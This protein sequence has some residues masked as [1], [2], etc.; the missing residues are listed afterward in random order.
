[1]IHIAVIGCGSIGLPI[2]VAFAA[3][4]IRVTGVD[5]DVDRLARLSAGTEPLTEP[6]LA[7]ALRAALAAGTINFTPNL[8][9]SAE[10][11]TYLIAVPTPWDQSSG[12]DDRPLAAAMS[13]IFAAARPGDTICI[14]STIPVGTTRRFADLAAAQNL[15]LDIISTPDRSIEG[16]SYREQFK[17]P[18][19]I[20][21][22][23]PEAAARAAALFSRLGEVFLCR[24]P[25][26]AEAA[27]LLCNVT[28]DVMFGLANEIGRICDALGVDGY[29]V[30]A[31]AGHL[32]PRFTLARPG[33]VGGPCLSK[34]TNLLLGSPN[35]P[36][37]TLIRAARA[38]NATLSE[39]VATTV[40]AHIAAHSTA[41]IA[42]LG[43]AFKG[44]PAVADLR[45]STALD[46]A[47]L[48]RRGPNIRQIAAWDAE[49]TAHALAAAGL[50]P[51]PTPIAAATDTTVLIIAN[52]H[53]AF[54]TMDI[55]ALAAAAHPHALLYDLC[56]VTIGK[57]ITLQPNQALKILGGYQR[58][59]T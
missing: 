16:S 13:A 23:N 57:P 34:D 48:L 19:L 18:H 54:T 26:E 40:N 30:R 4:N 41:K 9:P 22:L 21:A 12:F 43:V 2:A 8:T 58:T 35:A 45:G 39:H 56:G 53:A 46:I 47:I 49:V 27:K 42:L 1:M 25:E 17:I 38:A 5:T 10:H 31:A 52:D 11:R 33:P 7:A 28:R 24:Q 20:G 32:Y 51:A 37:S 44:R 6:D 3:R 50:D 55:S 29:A 14:R 15:E 59:G 36:D